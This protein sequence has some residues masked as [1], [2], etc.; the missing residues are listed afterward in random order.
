LCY[1]LLRKLHHEHPDFPR[2]AD[3]WMRDCTAASIGGP[4]AGPGG[5]WK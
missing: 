1:K 2:H 3:F 4:V 5:V